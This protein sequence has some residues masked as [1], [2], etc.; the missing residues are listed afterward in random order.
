MQN[1]R[2]CCY[3]QA[4]FSYKYIEFQNEKQAGVLS[5]I[6]VKSFNQD[7]TQKLKFGISEK[8]AI[9]LYLRRLETY[10][11]TLEKD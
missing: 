2:L 8:G 10:T 5:F 7:R 1:D 11:I 6:S 9:N 3:Q 4:T